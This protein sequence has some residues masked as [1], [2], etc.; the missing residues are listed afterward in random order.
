MIKYEV[1]LMFL[2]VSLVSAQQKQNEV[3]TNDVKNVWSTFL[4]ALKT[5]DTIAF[6]QLVAP[7]IRCYYCLENTP[8]EQEA[9]A[10][11]RDND[12]DWYAK[13]YEQDIYIPVAKFLAEDYDIIFTHTFIGLLIERETVYVYHVNEG[14]GYMEVLVTTT[15][16]TLLHEGG[17]HTFQFVKLKNRW[18]LNEIGTIP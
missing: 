15:K 13:I 9:L 7:K 6:K 14:V 16:P 2:F 18:V 3:S 1:V 10:Y 4:S 5:K 8:E 17:Q 11:S 12:K